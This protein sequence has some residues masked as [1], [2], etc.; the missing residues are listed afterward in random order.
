MLFILLRRSCTVDAV[1][2]DGYITVS[3]KTK[4][5]ACDAGKIKSLMADQVVIWILQ[6]SITKE[7]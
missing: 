6:M 7:A 4:K 3:V 1:V 2:G 5:L